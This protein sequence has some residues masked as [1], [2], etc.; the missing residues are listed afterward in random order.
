MSDSITLL[1]QTDEGKLLSL[2]PNPLPALSIGLLGL[3]AVLCSL[4]YMSKSNYLPFRRKAEYTLFSNL[5]TYRKSG[6]ISWSH[7][8]MR[9]EE[10][11]I[12]AYLSKRRERVSFIYITLS[13]IT[14]DM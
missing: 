1:P 3:L 8:Q 2:I 14:E 12:S 5:T 11:Y 13:S 4:I 7:Y 10:V 6:E 9:S